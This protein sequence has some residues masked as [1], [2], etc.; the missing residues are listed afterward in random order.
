MN[1]K[2]ERKN[3]FVSWLYYQVLKQIQDFQLQMQDREKD[4]MSRRKNVFEV[5]FEG[6]N[7]WWM[8]KVNARTIL[9]N[10][11]LIDMDPENKETTEEFKQRC[12][13]TVEFLKQL[14]KTKFSANAIIIAG[15]SGS[16]GHHTSVFVYDWLYNQTYSDYEK[17]VSYRNYLNKKLRGDT[18]KCS[19][20]V[21][22]NLEYSNHW[23]TGVEKQLT[24]IGLIGTK[25]EEA[26]ESLQKLIRIG[27]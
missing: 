24:Y 21:T 3:A 17:R 5:F 7:E 27:K 6:E 26:Y 11:I 2:V 19:E 8:D 25:Y 12:D 13:D 14:F 16:R 4:I 18:Q 10:E 22:I 15:P 23:K 9:K 1:K 20:K